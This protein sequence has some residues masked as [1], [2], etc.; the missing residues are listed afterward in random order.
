MNNPDTLA[1]DADGRTYDYCCTE[2]PKVL[3]FFDKHLQKLLSTFDFDG[4]VLDEPKGTKIVCHCEYCQ[5]ASG[6]RPTQQTREQSL[7]KFLDWICARIK[8]IKPHASVTIAI[9]PR[10]LHLLPD[11]GK[12][13]ACDHLSIDGPVSEQEWFPGYPLKKPSLFETADTLIRTARQFNKKGILF[14]ESF[15]VPQRVYEQFETALSDV[16][17]FKPDGWSFYYYPH[18]TEDP[19]RVMSMTR[20]A[21]RKLKGR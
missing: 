10:I 17:E 1:R 6:T 11:L 12:I 9:M 20:N 7:V 16:L 13:S 3:E 15:S 14:L 18:N 5:R 2:N 19:E 8:S 4:V 21:V